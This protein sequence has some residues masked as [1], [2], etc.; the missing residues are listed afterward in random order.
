MTAPALNVY[1]PACGAASTVPCNDHYGPVK[2]GYHKER[3]DRARAPRKLVAYLAH[4][5]SAPDQ[6]GVDV[7]LANARAWLRWL[8]ENTP[9]AVSAPW[10]PYVET[11]DEPTHR[12][13]GLADDLAMLERHDLIVLV[14]GRV[15]AGMALERGHAVK[16]GLRVLDLTRMGASPPEDPTVVRC[17]DDARWHG[18]RDLCDATTLELAK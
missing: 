16:R 11:L 1:C 13:R 18:L 15:S 12:A 4:P 2:D 6:A 5:V 7:N 8:V 10:M 14:G 3:L 9:W 17:D